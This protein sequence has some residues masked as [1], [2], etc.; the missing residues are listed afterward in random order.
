MQNNFSIGFLIKSDHE[1]FTI[2][3]EI[4]F[5]FEN[6]SLLHIVICCTEDSNQVI[7][8]QYVTKEHVH[9]LQN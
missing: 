8:E 9:N 1:S 7:H 3:V 6:S 2:L 4:D 5:V